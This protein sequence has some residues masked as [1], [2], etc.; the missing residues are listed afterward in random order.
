[1]SDVR[2][3]K[4]VTDIFD[5]EKILLIENLPK[6][7]SILIIWFKLLCLAGKQNNSGVFVMN[8]K[9]PY[10]PRMLATIF[11]RKE[12]IVKLALDTFE[13]YGMIEIADGTITIPN[14]GK[15][16]NFDKIEKSKEY[17]K[18]Y[19]QKYREK[20]KTLTETNCK[21]NS[22]VNSKINNK[23]NSKVNVNILDKE[24]EKEIEKNREENRIEK[25]KE[26][27]EI[28]KVFNENCY[29]LPK[30]A[31]LTD[32]R[33]VAIRKFLKEF[34]LEDFKKV[35]EL[36]NVNDFLTGN[37]DRGWKADFDFLLRTDKATSILE[38][39]YSNKK[40]KIDDFID[41]W[42]EA[43]NEEERNNTNNNSFGR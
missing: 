38:G 5:D 20:Q 22:K 25:D 21:T 42:E 24:E 4:I 39:K 36:A 29:N 1:M 43:K 6:A 33:K 15:H 40:D 23:T 41:L 17:M 13:Q 27:K 16:Q 18:D 12:S 11:R 34:T 9:I 3:I 14:W 37:N 32:K 8:N 31:K 7:D 35:C 19:M 26:Y 28:L 10:T 2:W 30:I